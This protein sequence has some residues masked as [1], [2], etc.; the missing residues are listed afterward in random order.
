MATARDLINRSLR[1]IGVVDAI[2]DTSS[3]DADAALD[4]FNDMVAGWELDGVPLGLGTMTLNTTL[5]VPDSH[6]E[7]LRANLSARLAPMFGRQAAAIV[8]EQASRGLRSLQSAYSRTRI[9]SVDP[10][11]RRRGVSLGWRY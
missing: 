5:A 9:M 8:I 1:E 7:A 4:V 10:A 6:L 11:L 2:E 3:E